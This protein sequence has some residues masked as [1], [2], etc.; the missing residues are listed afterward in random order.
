MSVEAMT[1]AWK[2]SIPNHMKI[3]LLAL[4][5]HANSDGLCWP[6][7]DGI[8]EKC[9]VK[10]RALRDSLSRLEAEG[11]IQRRKRRGAQGE[12]LSD[13]YQL[14]VQRQATAIGSALPSAAERT[15]GRQSNVSTG[16]SPLPPNRQRTTKEPSQE[17]LLF[18]H[19]K[20]ATG[21]NGR[22]LYTPKRKAKLRARLKDSTPDEI[23]QAI[24]Y[25]ADSDWHRVNGHTE[26]EL[27]CR[28]RD[29][30]EKY[31]AKAN[32]G[33]AKPEDDGW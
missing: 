24:T 18:E 10:P 30:I 9:S 5:D 19:W 20:D 31:L 12:Y 33:P 2:Q 32:T 26:L 1:W 3:V 7:Q 28:S 25:V 8:A 16:G 27:I 23:R 15:H 13:S 4:A 29:Q 17:R 22:T 11:L 6:G 21:R 14:P